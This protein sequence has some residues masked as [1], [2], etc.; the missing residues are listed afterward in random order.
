MD[1][2]LYVNLFLVVLLIGLTALFVGSEFSIIKVRLSRIDQLISE[3]HKG[4]K[5]TKKIID[6]LDYYLSACQLGIT[7]TALGLGWLGEPTVER[8]LHPLFDHL[9]IGETTSSILSVAIAFTLIT[10]IHVVIGELAPKTLAIQYA[11]NMAL[12]FSRPLIIFGVIMGPF[13]WLMNGSARVFLRMFGIEPA[14]HE[15][16][17]SEEELKIIMTHSYQ[18]GEINQTEL[19]YMQ[20]IFSFDERTAK[21]VMLPRTQMETISLEMEHPDL[22]EIV[23]HNQYTRY[24]VTENG[25]KDDIIGFI[26]V[27]E[28]LTNYTYKQNLKESIIVHDIPFV[29]ELAPLQDVLLKMQKERV[30]MAIVIDE[31]GGTAGV[32]TMED[33][34]EEIVGEIRDEFDEDEQ[35][36]IKALD[37]D[38]YLLNGRVL[39]A[40]LEERFALSFD[41]SE[42]VD[43]IGGWIQLKNTDIQEGGSIPLADHAVTVKEMENHQIISV[44]LTKVPEAEESGKETPDLNV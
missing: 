16:A 21:D 30:H 43:T 13:I 22:M 6:N 39:L 31:Y 9:S 38:N 36:D 20:N 25:D 34:L 12:F 33:I 14:G 4:A 28:M 3:G 7:V 37:A 10:Y 24:P 27:K 29:H 17:H 18:S 19:S 8:I 41:E 2:I 26:N 11:E 35:E 1:S 40:D 42:D 15:Q 23:R 5:R 44:L 32:I